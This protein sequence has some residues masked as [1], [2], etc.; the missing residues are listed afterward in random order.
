RDRS[1]A[2]D[3][4]HRPGPEASGIRSL[5]LPFITPVVPTSS[6]GG[7]RFVVRIRR[8]ATALTSHGLSILREAGLRVTRSA[9][10]DLTEFPF[11]RRAA[12]EDRTR[13]LPA[14]TRLVDFLDHARE[15]GERAIGHAHVLADL[16][17]HRRLRPLHALLHLVQDTH[18]LRF[19]NRHRLVFSAEEAG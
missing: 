19:R 11:A 18:G 3:S 17:R 8:L 2:T 16:E 9:L 5:S 7:F 4:P 1:V 12:A 14:R 15:R 6:A 10:L 13:D